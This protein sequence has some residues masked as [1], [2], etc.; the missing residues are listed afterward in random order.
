[1]EFDMVSASLTVHEETS[2]VAETLLQRVASGDS[3]AMEECLDRYGGLIWKIV[4]A[5]CNNRSDAED[6]VQEV[7]LDLWKSRLFYRPDLFPF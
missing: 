4:S 3:S 7:F 2:V 1:M 5:R 6:V